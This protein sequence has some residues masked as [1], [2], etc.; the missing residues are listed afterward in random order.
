MP[1]KKKVKISSAK[2]GHHEKHKQNFGKSKKLLQKEKQLKDNIFFSNKNKIITNNQSSFEKR[3]KKQPKPELKKHEQNVEEIL[4]MIDSDSDDYD[5]H[6]MATKRRKQ[7]NEED[8]NQNV[9]T[10]EY[11]YQQYSQIE[12]NDNGEVKILLPIKTKSGIVSQS[13]TVLEKKESNNQDSKVIVDKNN[14]DVNYKLDVELT[15]VTENKKDSVTTAE[16]LIEREENIQKQKFFIGVTCANIL[17]K[18]EERIKNIS[19]LLDMLSKTNKSGKVNLLPVRKICIISI[20]EVF[21]DIIPEYRIGIVDTE[22]QNLKKATLA[23]VNYENSLLTYY[24]KYLTILENF[25]LKLQKKRY[26]VNTTTIDQVQIAEI[27]TQCMCDLLIA[28][29]YFNYGMNIA[30][31]LVNLLNH[32]NVNLRN[33]VHS[34]F[35]IIFKSDNR[36]DLSKHIV[37]HINNLVKK[38]QHNVYPELVS[39]LKYLQIKD[40]NLNIEK[41]KELKKRKLEAHKS[42]L[43]NM[44]RKERKRKKKLTELEKELFETKAEENKQIKNSKLTEITKLVFTIFFRILKTAPT[45]KLLSVTLEGL[46]KFAHTI[47][48]EFFSDLIEILNN[49]LLNAE[50][51]YR[52]QLHCIQ[53]VFTIL[54]GQGDALNIDPARFYTHLYKNL[55]QVNAGKN[56]EYIEPILATLDNVLLKRRKT[57]SYHRYIAFIKR[58]LMMSLQLLHNSCLGCLGIVKTALQLNSS[59]DILLDTDSILGSGNYN[60]EIEEPE[61]CSANSTCIYEIASL[62]RHYHP[63]VR[64]FANNIANSVSASGNGML[65][66]EIGKLS[67]IELYNQYDSTK[68]IFNPAILPNKNTT[69]K[70]NTREHIFTEENFE[71]FCVQHIKLSLNED[72]TNALKLNFYCFILLFY[73]ITFI[74]IIMNKKIKIR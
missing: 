47:N 4:D 13:A 32:G 74:F 8:E 31:L 3:R 69:V 45:S 1:I 62:Q 73:F 22:T 51:G 40:I 29:P 56:H 55:L 70:N 2:R 60:P 27:A 11:E 72:T 44:S 58:L 71:Q 42:R 12:Q 14:V 39:C 64:K 48:I 35:V 43:I 57:I 5:F 23:R 34:C 66:S 18:P 46:S 16:L 37:R 6:G 49:I 63:I 33:T 28:H 30:Q 41:E 67:P 65:S 68:M 10:L 50:L 59:L 9:D 21:K 25:T 36:Y 54:S 53:T 38:K 17:E 52:E 20:V 19:T 26:Q 61:F 15:D 7:M 24:K